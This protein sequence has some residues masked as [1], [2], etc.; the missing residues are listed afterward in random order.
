MEAS[1]VV[2]NCD[3]FWLKVTIYHEVKRL[4]NI[5]CA[6]VKLWLRSLMEQINHALG[7]LERSIY[8]IDISYYYLKIV[9]L[10]E[11]EGVIPIRVTMYA[12]TNYFLSRDVWS[13]II[14]VFLN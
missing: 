1:D 13:N 4:L 3:R 5:E 14:L 7:E 2:S 6:P 11:S 12:V 10:D 9:E 8:Y